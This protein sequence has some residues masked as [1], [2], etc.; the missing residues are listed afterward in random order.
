MTLGTFRSLPFLSILL[1]ELDTAV[2]ALH[3]VS[4]LPVFLCSSPS[5]LFQYSEDAIPPPGPK[6]LRVSPLA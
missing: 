3:H 4:S 6:A 5:P 1:P 2:T